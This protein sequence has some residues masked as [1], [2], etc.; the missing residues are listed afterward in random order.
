MVVTG[1]TGFGNQLDAGDQFC[2]ALCDSA[3]EG[4]VLCQSEVRAMAFT[5]SM[6]TD[7]ICSPQ[8]PFNFPIEYNPT[9]RDAIDRSM[10]AARRLLL[11]HAMLLQGL[12]S[13]F[14]AVRYRRS[15]LM[16]V[17]M[18]LI[19]RSALAHES[20]RFVFPPVTGKSVN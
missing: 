13:I 15:P 19:L 10:Q 9:E 7:H 1:T 5:C 18:R 14:Q 6:S 4:N 12:S 2:L 17:L 3:K 16:R 20:M 8:D 11:P